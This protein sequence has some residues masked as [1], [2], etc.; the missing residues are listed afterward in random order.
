MSYALFCPGNFNT[1]NVGDTIDQ[2]TANCGQPAAQ[3]THTESPNLPQEWT[4]YVK[5]SPTD[6]ATIKMT[7][8]FNQGLVTN[9][10]V[11]GIGLSNTSVCGATVQIGDTTKTVESVCGKAAFIQQGNAPQSQPGAETKITEM[12]YTTQTGDTTLVFK[13]GLLQEQ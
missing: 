3:H 7:V 6:Q 11:N 2:V 13:N 4:Y 12:T 9:M 8:A 10:N 1:I 5:M